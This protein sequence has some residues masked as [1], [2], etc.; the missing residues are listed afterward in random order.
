MNYFFRISHDAEWVK[1]T[2]RYVFFYVRNYAHVKEFHT[3]WT[4]TRYAA[5]CVYTR[6]KKKKNGTADYVEHDALTAGSSGSR[7]KGIVRIAFKTK[8]EVFAFSSPYIDETVILSAR[9]FTNENVRSSRSRA[10]AVRRRV[11]CVF[12]FNLV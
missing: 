8:I 6:R 7:A 4:G 12:Q 10:L 3:N 1:D 5:Y 2:H 11:N 9:L